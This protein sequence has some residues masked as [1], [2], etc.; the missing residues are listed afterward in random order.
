M[1]ENIIDDITELYTESI[2][3]KSQPTEIQTLILDLGGVYFTNGSVLAKEII[4]RKYKNIDEEKLN[5][6]FSNSK[7]SPGSL[8]R[9]GVISIEEFES[10]TASLLNIPSEQKDVIHHI[11]FSSYVPNYMMEEIVADLSKNYRMIV[12]SGNIE[13]RIQY[14]NKKYNF[15]RF[16][17][18]HI[19][20]FDYK[21]N[22]REINLYYELLNHIN[23][24]PSQ[25]VLIDDSIKNLKRAN[26]VG[27][28]GIHYSYTEKFLKDLRTYNI[29]LKIQGKGI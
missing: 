7:G 19:F 14:L 21:T 22:K 25:A 13:E 27:L 6:A 9:R 28:N 3:L 10:K 29:D 2:N 8:I 12:F 24:K 1:T 23:C 5:Y 17:D 18:D 11:W 26:S 4:R 15:L 20:S 16:F